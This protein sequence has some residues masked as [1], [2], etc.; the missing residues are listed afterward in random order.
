[1]MNFGT[2]FRVSG[3]D[4]EALFKFLDENPEHF[5]QYEFGVMSLENVKDSYRKGE[6]CVFRIHL[7]EFWNEK[8]DLVQVYN[9]PEKR[10]AILLGPR[11]GVPNSNGLDARK[12][13]D[14]QRAL[15]LGR[16]EEAHV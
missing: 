15:Q 12:L 16:S 3:V 10:D 4:F 11:C 1:M 9:L 8:Y 14:G 6:M 7:G 5:H 13:S 2:M